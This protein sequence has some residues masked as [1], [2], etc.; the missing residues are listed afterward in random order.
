[1]GHYGLDDGLAFLG[2]GP[3]EDSKG[4]RYIYQEN[5]TQ[6]GGLELEGFRLALISLSVAMA[7]SSSISKFSISEL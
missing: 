4:N 3:T 2:F 7:S 5:D 1:M 6:K